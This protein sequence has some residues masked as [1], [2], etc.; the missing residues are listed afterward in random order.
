MDFISGGNMKKKPR[1]EVVTMNNYKR[2]PPLYKCYRPKCNKV[3]KRNEDNCICG[4]EIDWSEWE[5]WK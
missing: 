3:L 2:F 4:Q 1:A 5:E